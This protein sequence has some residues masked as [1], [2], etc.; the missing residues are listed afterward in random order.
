[1]TGYGTEVYLGPARGD[2]HWLLPNARGQAVELVDHDD[3]HLALT[4]AREKRL[5]CRTFNRPAR[6]TSIIIVGL[7]ELPAFVGLALDLGLCRLVLGIERVE[8]LV[9]LVIGGLP[10]I[11]GAT[12]DLPLVKR[13]GAPPA[14]FDPPRAFQKSAAHSTLSS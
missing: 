11:D 3:I 4:D 14:S 2:R 13:H 8:V 6:E 9:E 1:M 12:K 7:D 10:G 5:K